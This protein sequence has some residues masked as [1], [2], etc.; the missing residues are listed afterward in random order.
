M[1]NKISFWVKNL[2]AKIRTGCKTIIAF[3][4]KHGKFF[5]WVHEDP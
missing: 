3:S 1:A 2:G 4:E 5:P